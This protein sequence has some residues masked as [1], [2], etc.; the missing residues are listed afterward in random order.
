MDN[1]DLIL[2]AA[3]SVIETIGLKYEL[4][5][6]NEKE[7][8]EPK[9]QEALS[10]YS[11]ARRKLFEREVICDAG[12]VQEMNEIRQEIENAAKTENL[13]TALTRLIGFF[14]VL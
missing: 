9:Y 8:L 6:I 4:A 10:A 2:E 5:D 14:V 12:D 11:E 7:E 1:N 3:S 13:I